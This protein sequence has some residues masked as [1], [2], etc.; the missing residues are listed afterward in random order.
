MNLVMPVAR[1]KILDVM[2]VKTEYD[3]FKLFKTEDYF[4]QE[5]AR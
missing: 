1:D 2:T 3:K 4:S 5:V